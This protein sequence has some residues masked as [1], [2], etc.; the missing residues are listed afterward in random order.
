[1]E[2]FER[3]YVMRPEAEPEEGRGEDLTEDLAG[4]EAEDPEEVPAEDGALP[5]SGLH[6]KLY[7]AD[8]GWDARVWTG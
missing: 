8:A 3:V 4:D 1:L 5:L 7:V 6:A 2:D